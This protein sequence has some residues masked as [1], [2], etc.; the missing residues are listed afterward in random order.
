MEN[1]CIIFMHLFCIFSHYA[2]LPSRA[3]EAGRAIALATNDR[4]IE[5]SHQATTISQWI[6][7]RVT[8]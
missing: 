8:C 5:G 6:A 2:Y 1:R 7:T 4:V 3:T